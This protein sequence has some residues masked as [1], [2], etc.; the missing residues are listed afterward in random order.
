MCEL[1][2]CPKCKGY[3]AKKWR[4]YSTRDAMGQKLEFYF[5]NKKDF[6]CDKPFYKK[7]YEDGEFID[8]KDKKLVAERVDTKLYFCEKCGHEF[9]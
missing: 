3:G 2:V 8:A 6:F 7:T 5:N 1:K 9:K 4:Y